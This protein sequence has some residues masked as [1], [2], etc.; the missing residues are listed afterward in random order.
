MATPVLSIEVVDGFVRLRLDCPATEPVTPVQQEFRRRLDAPTLASLCTLGQSL[1]RS[2]GQPDFE[3]RARASGEILYRALVPER[4]HAPLRNLSGPL[5]LSTGIR[6]ILWELLYDGEDFWGL[7]YALGRRLV[8]YRSFPPPAAHAPRERPRALV[9]G[10]DPRGD[11]PF[12]DVEVAAVCEM[13][14][15]TCDV[16]CVAGP[17]ATPASVTR[18]FSTGFDLIHY[19]GHA[20]GASLSLADGQPLDASAIES[21]L[22]GRAV[23]FLNACSSAASGIDDTASSVAH[24]F[25]FGG[26]LA[27][28][29]TQSEV[30]DVH[31]RKVA[32]TF[33]RR[34]LTGTPAGQ[35]LAE[36]RMGCRVESEGRSNA[37]LSFTLYG[38]PSQALPVVVPRRAEARAPVPRPRRLAARWLALL[39]GLALVIAWLA[40]R[41]V[42]PPLPIVVGLMEV[43]GRGAPVSDWL[44]ELTRDELN[45]VLSK[46]PPIRVVA[47]QKIEF[48][49]RRRRLTELEA[50]E[51]LGLMKMLSATVEADETHVI[52]ELEIVDMASGDLVG[53]AR[54]EGG[55]Q[56]LM[57]LE[58][59][60][61]LRAVRLLGVLP[62]DQEVRAALADRGND[63]LRV[64]RLFKDTLGEPQPSTPADGQPPPGSS[65][66]P[67]TAVAYAA[68]VDEIAIRDLL[69]RYADA[70]STRNLDALAAVQDTVSDAQRA[71]LRSYFDALEALDVQVRDVDVL[72]DGDEAIATFTRED[73]VRDRRTHR[74]MRLEVRVAGTL[75][76]TA[77][78]WKIVGLR[79]PP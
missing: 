73:R 32:E 23:V 5:L 14:A 8:S 3:A 78:G 65:G 76:R 75:R 59:E 41:Y 36:A 40:Y 18:L 38:D 20:S 6:G 21:A 70:L 44:R 28:V 24:G 35:A 22:R 43:R 47:R 9:V 30:I 42:A 29:G 71:A 50:A 57:D 37:W 68:D 15:D 19:C 79:E 77:T 26:A 74:S 7:R 17:L 48:V 11:L 56:R 58:H 27:V 33:Y 52:L 64:Y 45:T 67:W 12:V 10:S 25:L 46:F 55:P 61:A 72:V 51:T 62:T 60:L 54:V 13:L 49:Q 31:A 39:G 1:L 66:L 63:T 4:L 69:A 2:A 53:T 16:T 34:V